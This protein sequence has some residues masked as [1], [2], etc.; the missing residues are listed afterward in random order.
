MTYCVGVKTRQGIVMGSD[1]RTN[2]GVDNVSVFC[3]T[4]RFCLPG[5]RWIGAVC[6]GH[7][8]VTQGVFRRMDKAAQTM[9]AESWR[10]AQS[11][12]DVADL[13]GRAVREE[14]EAH[15]HLQGSGV[16][17][18]CN[19]IVAGQIGWQE[20]GLFLVY[21]EGNFIEAQDG[22]SFFQIGETK[23][24]KPILDRVVDMDTPLEDAAKCA[25]I[26]FDSTMRSNLSVGAPV[27]LSL[28]RA[29]SLAEA[30]AWR[31]GE[32]DAYFKGLREEWSAGLRRVFAD[33]SF[34]PAG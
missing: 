30:E 6:S 9:G 23:Y 26:S 28:Y 2:A 4:R 32:D 24:G 15:S 20:P 18:S 13:F 11:M 31:F 3:K 14:R 27:D 7:L 34:P 5:D 19:F 33:I 29:G 21:A 17:S 10:S 1:S 8:G 25:L 16:D 12:R 22:T